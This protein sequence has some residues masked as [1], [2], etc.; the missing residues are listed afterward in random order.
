MIFVSYG[1][2]IGRWNI[3]RVE[4]WYDNGN[5]GDYDGFHGVLLFYCLGEVGEVGLRLD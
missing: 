5:N 2:N 3:E 1:W 4:C